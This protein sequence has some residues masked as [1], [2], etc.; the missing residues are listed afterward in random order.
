MRARVIGE[1]RLLAAMPGWQELS[2]HFLS[3][4]NTLDL[5]TLEVAR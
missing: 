4:W 2:C 1:Q 3:R 5:V